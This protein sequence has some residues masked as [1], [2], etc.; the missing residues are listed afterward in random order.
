MDKNPWIK[1]EGN[2]ISI[3]P[4]EEDNSKV[5]ICKVINSVSGLYAFATR[6]LAVASKCRGSLHLP[7]GLKVLD[8]EGIPLQKITLFKKRWTESST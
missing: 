7:G 1:G 6:N 3:T 4:Q 2:V 8:L 5:L